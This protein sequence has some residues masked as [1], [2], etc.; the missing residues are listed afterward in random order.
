[1]KRHLVSSLMALLL[2][3][4]VA[5]PAIAAHDQNPSDPVQTYTYDLDEV[6][7]NNGGDTIDG[8]VRLKGL[9]N[10]KVQVRVEAEGLAPNL[11]HAQHLH[12]ATDDNGDFVRG[13]CPGIDADGALERPTDGLVDTVEGIPDYGAVVQSL[14]TTGDTSGASG[15]AVDRFPVADEDGNLTYERTF[16]PSGEHADA[17]HE[18]LGEVEVVIHGID[19]N[20][21]GGYDFEAGTSSL[22]G[23]LPL[24]ATIPALCG[25][26]NG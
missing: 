24:E 6:A 20:D 21:S 17:V 4:A 2:V 15:L 13:V 14:T 1:M 16:T 12:V 19:L 18:Q 7:N 23:D 25:G 3:G 22:S 5:V 10:G 11:P 9:P 8:T 26:P